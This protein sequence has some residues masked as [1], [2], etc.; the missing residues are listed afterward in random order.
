MNRDRIVPVAVVAAVAAGVLVALSQ[1]DVGNRPDD[2][3]RHRRGES[4]LVELDG[5]KAYAYP[6]DLDDGGVEYVV[7]TEAPCVRR[8]AGAPVASCKRREPDGGARDFGALNRFPRVE[9]VGDGCEGVACSIVFGEDSLESE[10]V[11]L[12]RER[13]RRND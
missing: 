10:D 1:G 9:A 7:T 4:K 12:E 13:G 11:K 5:G 6:T 3:R 2:N 8:P